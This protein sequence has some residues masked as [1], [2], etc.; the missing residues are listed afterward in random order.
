[1]GW[2]PENWNRWLSTALASRTWC[3]SSKRRGPDLETFASMAT[4]DDAA[5][6]VLGRLVSDTFDAEQLET[7]AMP[8]TMQ[9]FI[10]S[11]LATTAHVNRT[12]IAYTPT[13][14]T[15]ITSAVENS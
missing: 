5:T 15:V 10:A 2:I 12:R 13:G 3:K 6:Y 11:D 7:G 9:K 4:P 14:S 8:L 1:M